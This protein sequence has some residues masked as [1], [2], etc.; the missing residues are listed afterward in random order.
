[1]ADK[2]QGRIF[3]GHTKQ[4]PWRRYGAWLRLLERVHN[5]I[6]EVH[7]KMS[8]WLCQSHCVVLCHAFETS[9]VAARGR[10][11]SARKLSGN[12]SRTMCTWGGHYLVP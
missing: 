10:R 7:K 1:M 4:A 11:T 2:L 8:A 12:T 3:K 6:D 5:M 9:R